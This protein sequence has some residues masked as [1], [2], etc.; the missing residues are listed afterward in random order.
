MLKIIEKLLLDLNFWD[1]CGL[2]K[3]AGRA[4]FI[5]NFLMD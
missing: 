2:L 5:S 3:N 4:L 1:Y